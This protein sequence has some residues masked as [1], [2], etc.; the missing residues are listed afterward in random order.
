M[1][2]FPLLWFLNLYVWRHYDHNRHVL[3]FVK[4][5]CCLYCNK[6]R[7]SSSTFSCFFSHKNIV[8]LKQWFRWENTDMIGPK[9]SFRSLIWAFQSKQKIMSDY[10]IQTFMTFT[11]FN[12][13]GL[14]LAPFATCWYIS[15]ILCFPTSMKSFTSV[16]HIYPPAL[17]MLFCEQYITGSLLLLLWRVLLRTWDLLQS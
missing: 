9:C 15:T 12:Y 16:P 6:Q 5:C 3:Q 10:V 2:H 1:L 14:F 11:F 17:K 7:Y 8:C 4:L 13:C